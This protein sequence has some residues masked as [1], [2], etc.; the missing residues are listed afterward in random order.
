M[1][2]HRPIQCLLAAPA[3]IWAAGTA[4]QYTPWAEEDYPL[5]LYWGDTH[6]HSSYSVDAN[7]MGNVG[8]PP[9]DAYR[10]A[11]GEAVTANNGMV[12][13]LSQP[14]DFLVVSDHAE[15]LG[16]MLK[17][18]EGDARLLT[19]PEAKRIF[20]AMKDSGTGDD[21][22]MAVMREFLHRMGAGEAMLSNDAVSSE[23]WQASIATSDEF[24]DPGRFTALIGFEWTSMPGSNNLHRVVVYAD[25]AD[26]AGQMQPISSNAGEDPASLWS[27]MERYEQ[28]TGGRILAIPHNG[29]LSNG[30]M[31]DVK[32]FAGK[33]IDKAYAERRARLEPIAEVTQIKGDGETHPFLSPDD[34]FA[35]FETWD[36]GNFAAMVAANKTDDMLQYEYARSALKIGLALQ[37][38]AGANPYKFGMI[39]STDAHTSLAT[40]AEDNF[41]GKA[42]ATEPG[43]GRTIPGYSGM[44]GADNPDTQLTKGWTFVASGYTGVW[45]RDNT[46]KE[47]FDAMQRREVYATTG[48]RISLRLFGGFDYS[49]ADL[50]D[51]HAVRIGYRKGVPMGGE[52]G[53]ADKGQ[54]PGFMLMAMKDPHGANLDRLQ[55][56]KGWLEDDGALKEKVYT[57]A[58]SDGRRIGRSGKVKALPSTVDLDSA[59]YRNSVGAAS[60][61]AFWQDPDFEP[62]Q[63]AF[64]YARVIEI[65]TPRWSVYD[66]ARLGKKLDPADPKVVQD[67][68]Y[69]S[70][71]WYE[72][73]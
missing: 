64:Y 63:R 26:R 71:I 16:T 45:A 43:T 52:L 34:E 35:D 65:E 29:N 59:S 42:T 10:F 11:R 62:S 19:D 6:L 33:P 60:L 5:N 31:F 13:K 23:I 53:P 8:L 46:R 9:A 1:S 48:S 47:I 44:P 2:K 25:G 55:V 28:Q 17:L 4:A 41:W 39:G 70:P 66:A 14:L 69:S 54:A 30:L 3:L 40:G 37:D 27:F 21:S 51:P 20:E 38:S 57:V 22:A 7:T 73:R 50:E 36:G 58:A 67:R 18:R 68:A 32:D 56:I 49:S 12:A 61:S 72:P 24:N 15:Q